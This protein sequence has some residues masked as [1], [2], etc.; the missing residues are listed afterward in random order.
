MEIVERG[1]G[2]PLVF[3]PGIQGR[4][5]YQRAAVEALAG[6]FRVITFSLGDESAAATE[7]SNGGL[8][9]LVDQVARALDRAGVARAVICGVSF[10]GIVALRFAAR[11]PERTTA[12][13]LVSTPGPGWR[14]RPRHEVYARR[15]RLY[16]PLF[17][18]E[19][20]FRLRREI[21]IAIPA[22]IDR[23]RFALRQLSTLARAPLSLSR[24][25]ARARLIGE[26][27]PANGRADEC[28]AVTAPT[29]I[30]HG[31]PRLDHVVDA[32]GTAEYG[33]LIRG[34]TITMI[35]GTGHLGSVTRP[36]VFADA[37]RR[38]VATAARKQSNSAA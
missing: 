23:L 26:N 1:R 25:A 33:R 13:V 10:G 4:W 22:R 30:I 19:T 29:L 12:L 17:I 24:M 31:D 18:L 5:E 28:A 34:A 37:V 9:R 14:L 38:F 2:E 21:A 32:E 35:D 3:V 36:A 15:P 6:A 16:G 27:G 11:H 20:P 8:D 7:G